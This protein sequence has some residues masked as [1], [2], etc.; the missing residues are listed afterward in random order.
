M[1]T[2]SRIAPVVP[3]AELTFRPP[4]TTSLGVVPARL[5]ARSG[6]C[7]YRGPQSMVRSSSSMVVNTAARIATPISTAP[8]SVA[9]IVW[10]VGSATSPAAVRTRGRWMVSAWW[11][12][13]WPSGPW[14]FPTPV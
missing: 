7:A 1:N 2:K 4:N 3:Q 6:S 8:S 14:S 9:A 13:F 10:N 5:A 12:G 11:S